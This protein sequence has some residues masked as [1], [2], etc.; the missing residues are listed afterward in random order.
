LETLNRKDVVE[1]IIIIHSFKVPFISIRM[2]ELHSVPDKYCQ[3]RFCVSMNYVKRGERK[4]LWRYHP[5]I[6]ISAIDACTNT[7]FATCKRALSTHAFDRASLKS[8]LRH[9]ASIYV[10]LS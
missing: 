6:L 9:D 8:A 2:F 5:Y 1:I 7:G 3:Y 10:E 4:N